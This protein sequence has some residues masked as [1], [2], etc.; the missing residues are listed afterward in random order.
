[1][2]RLNDSL[3]RNGDVG[4]FALS[5]DS[6]RVVYMADQ[7]IDGLIELYAVAVD[8]GGAAK[9]NDPLAAR[10]GGVR[11]FT[12]SPDGGFVAYLAGQKAGADELFS[13]PL[14]GG[15]VTRMNSTLVAGGFVFP[16]FAISSDSRSI[17]YRAHQHTR[18]VAELYFRPI[19]GPPRD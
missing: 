3:V 10:G 17:V 7:E 19:G 15:A 12:I 16:D 18:G 1:V 11:S 9:L 8:G 4:S 13:V 5:P 6:S 2:T 14:G